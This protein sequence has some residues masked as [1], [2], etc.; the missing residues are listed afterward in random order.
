MQVRPVPKPIK[1]TLALVFRD[2][3]ETVETGPLLGCQPLDK[4]AMQMLVN[5]R[6]HAG[7]RTFEHGQARQQYLAGQ[8]P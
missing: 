1:R 3:D 8:Q 6:S 7:D 4:A 2:Y 5:A